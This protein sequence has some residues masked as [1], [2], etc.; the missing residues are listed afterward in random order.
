MKIN[1]ISKKISLILVLTMLSVS[2]LSGCG[3]KDPDSGNGDGQGQSTVND[4]G[5]NGGNGGSGSGDDDAANHP[6]QARSKLTGEWKDEKVAN[7]RPLAITIANNKPAFPQRGVSKASVIIEAPMEGG[8]NTRLLAIVEDYDDVDY[9]CPVRSVRHYF[10]V[11]SM[12]Y[13]SILCHWGLSVAYVGSLINSDDIDNVSAAVEGVDRPW[14]NAFFRSKERQ[15][16][17]YSTEYTGAMMVSGRESYEQAVKELGYRTEYSE[18]FK[19]DFLF[20]KDGKPVTYDDNPDAKI[21][22]LGGHGDNN[23][24]YGHL[25]PYFEYNEEDGLYHRYNF[26][27]DGEATEMTDEMN[28]EPVAVKNVI[29]QIVSGH[30][31]DD[32]GYLVFDVYSTSPSNEAYVFTEGK[33]IKA[34]WSKGFD[35]YDP[36][37]YYDE[38]GEEIVLNQGKTW[39]CLLWDAHKNLLEYE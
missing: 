27:K 18:N 23:S 36:V 17:G 24:G 11:D 1:K 14:D 28:D 15:Q 2:V 12:P 29:V 5:D 37:Y 33:M 13:D 25:T 22:R 3:R 21:I 34:S 26:I 9:F 19:Q 32:N 30:F 20:A 39:I 8:L 35:R 38:D 16:D 31:L 10:A 6:G 7:R 4:G